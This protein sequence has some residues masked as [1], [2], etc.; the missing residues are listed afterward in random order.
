MDKASFSARVFSWAASHPK[1]MLAA[2]VLAC[3]L[4]FLAK[5]V[6]IDDPLFIWTARH[7]QQHPTNPYGF[8]VNW[9][10]T[11]TPMW[12]ATQNPPLAAYYLALAGGLLGWGEI[13]LHAALVLPAL[14]VVLGTH[15][16][17]R[18]FC[19]SPM[20]A[21]LLTLFTPAFLVSSTTLMCD[22]LLLAWWIWAI[23]F[24]VEGLQR[25]SAWRLCVAGLLIG[26]AFLTKY[27]GGMLIP[28]V[29]AYS[30]MTK[31]RI[32]SW[33][34]WLLIPLSV[35]LAYDWVS[36]ALYGRTLFLGAAEYAGW[37]KGLL[38]LLN[39]KLGS[40]LTS[41]TFT[42]GSL[43]LV[44]FGSPLL[45]SRKSLA[46]VALATGLVAMVLFLTGVVLKGY[47]PIAGSTRLVLEGQIV[48]W[49]MGGV[50]IVLLAI[51]DLRAR[52]DPQAWLLGLW[53][54]GTFLFSALINWTVNGRSILPMAPAV[55]IL[56]ARRLEIKPLTF[57]WRW[58]AAS[59]FLTLGAALALLVTRADYLLAGAV[60]ES[61]RQTW[62]K[63]GR[64][65]GKLWFQ[66]HWGFQYYMEAFGASALDVLKSELKPGDHVATPANNTNFLP[67]N[68]EVV[69]LREEILVAGPSLLTTMKGEV[70][71][72]FYAWHCGPLPFAIGLAPP[73]RVVVL[74]LERFP[75]GAGPRRP[76]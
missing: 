5:P 30:A 66:G 13:A 4:P 60:R 45:W 70:G 36:R 15:R 33:I 10:G 52:H 61:A 3:L 76:M 55:G 9:F 49:A 47:G 46:W 12:K 72:G 59:V 50:S 23:V 17:A 28:L 62:A 11:T 42:G 25:D 38:P 44:T 74:R 67:L 24:W 73:E 22:V 20:L 34:A 69:S 68:P 1:W 27:F 26:L 71:A 48:F 31:R 53:V 43:A 14:A 6:H 8:E 54:L 37:P 41:L 39:S 58:P 65:S 21:A 63:Y 32:G 40:T 2:L 51:S 56:V 35:I 75:P 64:A 7:I 57:G 29:A 18:H 16:L 19:Q